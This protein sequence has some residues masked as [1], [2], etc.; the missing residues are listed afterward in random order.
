MGFQHL[1]TPKKAR[2]QGTCDFLDRKS[3]SYSHNDVFKFHGTSKHTGWRILSKPRIQDGRTY[4]STYLYDARGRK[5]KITPEMLAQIEKFIDNNGFDG[6]TV[7]W[8]GIPA[9]VGLDIDVSGDTVRRAVKDLNLRADVY[10]MREEI[11]VATTPG[12]AG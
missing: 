2:V 5:R 8:A 9:A 11:Y 4:H 10:R 1:L 3:I 6:R 7:R 12:M